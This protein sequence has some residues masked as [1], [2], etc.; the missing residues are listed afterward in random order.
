MRDR[1]IELL[2]VRAADLKEHPS[3]WH[4]H[5]ARQKAAL[6]GV[7][8]EIGYAD[9]LIARRDE[10]GELVL[11]DGHLRK[12]LSP[13]QVVPV[14]IVDVDEHEGEKLLALLDP[15]ASL[16]RADAGKLTDLLDRVGTTDEGIA[17]LLE[18]LRRSA[19]SDLRRLLRDPN[20]IPQDPPARTK[21]G[22]LYVL[23]EHRL[24][25]GDARS[26]EDLARLVEGEQARALI[27]DPPYGVEVRGR[28]S[29][30][31]SIQG[32]SARGLAELLD[33]SFAAANE[34]LVPGSA[35][36]VFSPSGP[37]LLVFGQAFIAQGWRLHQTLVW[38]KR[39]VLGHSDYHYAHETILY[40]YTASDRP[41][42]RG[43][44]GFYGG[45]DQSSV[46]EFA[47][48]AASRDHP[49]TK[50]VEL[51][52]HLV[53]NSSRHGQILLDPFAGSGGLA[54]AAERL[55]RRAFLLEIDPR[56]CD[57][58]LARYEQVTGKEAVRA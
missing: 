2:R 5:S 34:V 1:V 18:E 55:G 27:T 32:D 39:P 40:G 53:S 44:A 36:Y 42:G 15:I 57:V 23:G 21:P 37:N 41:K 25:C 7:L 51:L 49:T 38:K 17:D 28:T 43:K 6:Q 35:V 10:E 47:R 3:N 45:N 52:E 56:Y 19:A 58:I 12:S 48:P 14:I 46:L 9:V 50:P 24:L 22:D 16:A 29:K 20:E 26:P 33:T 4:L 11:L 31:L 13:E 8:E 54:V 30:R